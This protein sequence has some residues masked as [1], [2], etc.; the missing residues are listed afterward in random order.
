[1][2]NAQV[3]MM[4]IPEEWW[5]FPRQVGLVG[6][7]RVIREVVLVP[8]SWL[9][10]LAAEGD[11]AVSPWLTEEA[12]WRL[13]RLHTHWAVSVLTAG[14]TGIKQEECPLLCL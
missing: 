11:S 7:R 14:P 5:D 13:S 4:T 9:F 10:C 3:Q 6:T 2:D 12:S 1:M 8:S